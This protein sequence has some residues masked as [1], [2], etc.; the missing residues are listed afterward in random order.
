MLDRGGRGGEGEVGWCVVTTGGGAGLGW[1]GSAALDAASLA[2]SAAPSITAETRT[3]VG[4]TEIFSTNLYNIGLH[5]EPS[6]HNVES[7]VIKQSL[8]VNSAG[9]STKWHYS[10]KTNRYV[11]SLRKTN[12]YN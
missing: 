4:H 1:G 3:D 10:F 5:S 11:S 7:S 9:H 2:E 12:K 8:L 6:T